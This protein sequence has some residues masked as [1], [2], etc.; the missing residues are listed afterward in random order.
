MNSNNRFVNAAF[1][2]RSFVFLASLMGASSASA[3]MITRADF[4]GSETLETFSSGFAAGSSVLLNGVT[5]TY[6]NSA[7][8]NLFSA[9]WP[10]FFPNVPDISTGGALTASAP[11]ADVSVDF[12]TQVNRIGFYL[13][14][15]GNTNWLV[16]VFGDSN[17][18]LGSGTFNTWGIN[19][20]VGAAFVGFEF[21]ENINYFQVLQ[22][23]S[24][25]A[26]IMDD[27]RYESVATV[28]APSV[29]GLFAVG[30]FLLMRNR[31]HNLTC[32]GNTKYSVQNKNSLSENLPSRACQLRALW[33]RA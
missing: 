11:G 17:Q 31:T 6:N 12:S 26:F 27:L 32:S 19:P 5:Y 18:L 23:D 15:G 3:S 22:E 24:G 8:D 13:T 25:Y 20:S 28:P 7:N 10:N 29:L 16:N 1:V 33:S 2:L 14:T 4:S 30:L 21:A 9:S